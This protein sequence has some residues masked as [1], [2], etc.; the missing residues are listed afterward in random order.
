MRGIMGWVAVAALH[1]CGDSATNAGSTGDGAASTDTV[2]DATTADDAT[3]ASDSTSTTGADATSGDED[4]AT[5]GADT[6]TGAPGDDATT[7]GDDGDGAWAPG[8]CP[9]IYSQN[10]LPTFEL[11]VAA[12]EL[13]AL[14]A[15]WLAQDTSKPKHPL[16]L[17]KYEDIEITDASI[18]LRGHT[19]WWPGQNKMQFEIEFHTYDEDGRF[20]GLKRMLFD[21][22]AGN[23]SFLRDR[24]A[25]QVMRDVGLPAPCANNARLILNGA[26][27]GL[28]TSIE[29]VD[30]EF[31]ERNF[32][33]PGGNLYKRQN[34]DKTSNEDDPDTSDIDA[35]LAVDDL[36]ALDDLMNLDEA[37][38]E[39]AT[40][41]VL[42]DADGAWAG[43]YNFYA[44]N[45]PLTGFV[46]IPWDKDATFTR[47]DPDVDP[48]TY[49]KPPEVFHGR[50]F[51]DI[52][53]ADPA[54]FQR[55][56]EA[57]AFALDEGYRVDLLQ[58]RIDAWAA[59]I[60]AAA[61]DDPNRPFTFAQHLDAV[62]DKR[63]FVAERHAFVAGWLK[64]WQAG[65]TKD[66]D[67]ECTP[68]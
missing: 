30:S 36:A 57:V 44:Y 10:L 31:L 4:D 23:R 54:W 24:L 15:E 33:D 49:K 26:Y 9:G 52:T 6:T 37:V 51:Y 66:S 42:P 67:G 50:E 59:Q 65:G 62:E 14:E 41:A 11:E 13:A 61:A 47:L 64:C 7:D 60:E 20:L 46:V 43:G 63:E 55:Y 8:P 39:W 53:T 5:T 35:L 21:A 29:K 16:A 56:I 68:P 22:A 28:F 18:A 45:D 2:S 19:N 17:F 38:L 25:L 27:Y 34:W 3:P 1:G 32:E 40:E 58:Q 12:D 48:Y